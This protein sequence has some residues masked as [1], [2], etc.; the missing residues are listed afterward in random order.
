MLQTSNVY[1]DALDLSGADEADAGAIAPAANR[2]RITATGK[3]REGLTLYQR[4]M[5]QRVAP[6]PPAW[7]PAAIVF[8]TG[9]VL[10]LIVA[11]GSR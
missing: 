6:S 2:V 4:I 10:A 1:G 7:L 5:A 11:L 8:A 9:A 3:H